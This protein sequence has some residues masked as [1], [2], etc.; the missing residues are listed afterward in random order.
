MKMVKVGLALASRQSKQCHLEISMIADFSLTD[1]LA[2]D[3]DSQL[4]MLPQII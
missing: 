4:C 2:V 3:A 1:E